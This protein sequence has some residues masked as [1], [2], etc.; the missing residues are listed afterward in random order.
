MSTT[1]DLAQ[2]LFASPLQPSTDL[3]PERVR[4]AIE[5]CACDAEAC[6]AYVAQEAGDHPESYVTRMR[7]ALRAV[8]MAYPAG[9]PALRLAA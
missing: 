8:A 9:A 6:A 2:V 5:T 4:A 1:S 3:T 7:W